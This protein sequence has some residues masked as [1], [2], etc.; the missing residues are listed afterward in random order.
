MEENRRIALLL[1]EIADGR[2]ILGAN[3][4]RVR[5]FRNAATAI[6]HLDTPLRDID[7]PTSL[8]GVGKGIAALV[9][10]YF[11]TGQMAD[12]EEVRDQVAPGVRELLAVRGLGPGTVRKLRDQGIDGP[13]E[14][15]ARLASGDDCGLGARQAASA[16]EGLAYYLRFRGRFLWPEGERAFEALAAA[17]PGVDLRPAGAFRRFEEV[18]AEV[19]AIAVGA[20]GAAVAAALEEPSVEGGVVRGRIGGR[21]A[22][23]ALA[24][25]GEAGLAWILATAK[26]AHLE[27]LS[28]GAAATEEEAYAAAGEPFWPPE[29]R[30]WARTEFPDGPPDLVTCDDVRGDLHTHTDASDGKSTLSE[31]ADAAAGR[32]YE[33]LAVTDHSQTAAYA[34]GLSPDRLRER[35]AEIRA[36]DWPVRL[37]AGTESD[38][39]P[40]GSLDYED[41]LL[42]ELDWVV[43]SV[44]QGLTGDQTE[45]VLEAVAHP[46]VKVLGHPTGRRLLL[47]DGF[48]LDWDRLLP[49]LAESGTMLEINGNPE[50]LDAEAEVARKAAQE[51]VTVALST[52]AHHVR[53]LDF[54]RRAVAQARRAGLT[55]SQVANSRTYDSLQP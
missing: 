46:A 50:R 16:R 44:H 38:I 5:A 25:P 15:E 33:Y 1:R 47:R 26:A 52:D 3:P 11:E 45:R 7:D 41:G 23:V 48:E 22:R 9:A 19:E 8:K 2:E 55:A 4:F 21:D 24:E 13:A 29:L 31:M 49:A 28:L 36:G 20:G 12:A 32:G 51:G 27:G 37:L 42:G 14:L 30:G 43:A 53:H 10:E 35:L 6:L 40:D 17:L 34:G 18:L 54:M 39:L